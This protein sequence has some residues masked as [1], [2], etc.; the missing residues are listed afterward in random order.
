MEA[1]LDKNI[2]EK[3]NNWVC[4]AEKMSLHTEK[5]RNEI[6]RTFSGT[7]AM[8][9]TF[10]C[11]ILPTINL[12]RNNITCDGI[13]IPLAGKG[14][15][16]E[17]FKAFIRRPMHSFTREELIA[18]IYGKKTWAPRTHRMDLALTQNA[19]KL[20]S[21]TRALAEN[22]L[23]TGQTKWIEW[24]CYDVERRAWSFYRLTNAYLM[25]KQNTLLGAQP[26][27]QENP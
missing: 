2:I 13:T 11:K 10:M 5:L 26:S 15:A 23:N 16:I 17:L 22:T 19:I 6:C 8:P 4:C 14:R 7:N 1:D 21:R 27:K 12:Y 24:F 18:E 25:E 3:I 20:I 9:G